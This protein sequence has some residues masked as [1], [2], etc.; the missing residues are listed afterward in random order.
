MATQSIADLQKLTDEKKVHQFLRELE[1]SEIAIDVQL[2][3]ILTQQAALKN[4]LKTLNQ[5][6]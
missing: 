5:S 4:E 3:Q 6:K 2:D 1:E